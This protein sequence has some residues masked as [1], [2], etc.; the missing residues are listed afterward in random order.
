M[1]GCASAQNPAQ[2]AA[3][4]R[5][6]RHAESSAPPVPMPV[7][8]ADSRASGAQKES[9]SPVALYFVRVMEHPE[10][11]AALR[12]HARSEWSEETLTFLDREKEFRERCAQHSDATQMIADAADIAQTYLAPNAPN[13]LNLPAHQLGRFKEGIGSAADCHAT[14]FEDVARSTSAGNPTRIYRCSL[15]LLADLSSIPM[16]H[17]RSEVSRVR[18]L[19]AL[20][21]DPQCCRAAPTLS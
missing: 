19:S 12:A 9:S 11:V 20:Q 3:R 4:V 16:H 8:V 7:P 2:P 10:A 6:A 18:P 14:M 17:S 13:A 15:D 5:H 21:A 1:G